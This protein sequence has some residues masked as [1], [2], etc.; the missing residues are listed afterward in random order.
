MKSRSV[1]LA[2]VLSVAVCVTLAIA[3][4]QRK[5]QAELTKKL[6]D[7]TAQRVKTA[8]SAYQC[9]QAAFDADTVGITDLMLATKALSEAELATCTERKDKIAVLQKYCERCRETERRVEALYKASSKGGEAEKFHT[10][11]LARETADIELLKA[12]LARD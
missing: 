10:V 5:D 12:Q 6:D 8:T 11:K 4:D 1:Y 2:G 7:L 9:T 3:A